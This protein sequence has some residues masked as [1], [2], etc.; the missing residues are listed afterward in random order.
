VT[1]KRSAKAVTFPSTDERFAHAVEDDR[2][3]SRAAG[4]V[5]T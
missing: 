3:L 4:A 5:A 1:V 2:V